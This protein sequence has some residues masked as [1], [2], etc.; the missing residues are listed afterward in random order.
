MYELDR[1]GLHTIMLGSAATRYKDRYTVEKIDYTDNSKKYIANM[2]ANNGIYKDN[3]VTL[4]GDVT[5]VR[6]DG[7][8]FKTQKA[9][10]NKKTS[11]IVSKVG[12]VAY[13]NGSIVKGSYIRYNN[14]KNRIFSKNVTAKIQLK[15][16]K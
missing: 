10:Y 2:K 8:T 5:Y 6:E 13:L 16:E 14:N 15:E 7:L 11:N 9:T 4:T 3:F 12:Y 1:V